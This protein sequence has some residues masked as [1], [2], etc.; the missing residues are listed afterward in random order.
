MAAKERRDRK[1]DPRI[2]TNHD[3]QTAL[4]E[5]IPARGRQSATERVKR[6][7]EKQPFFHTQ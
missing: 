5:N 1:D 4:P 7:C 6:W 3:I 2:T